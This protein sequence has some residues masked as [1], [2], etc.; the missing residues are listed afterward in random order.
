VL[1]VDL[2]VQRHRGLTI[3]DRQ[4]HFLVHFHGITVDIGQERD[5]PASMVPSGCIAA[6]WL[7]TR[8]PIAM[9]IFAHTARA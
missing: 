5:I 8:L 9:R 1:K 4:S 6:V 7:A 2:M 3:V